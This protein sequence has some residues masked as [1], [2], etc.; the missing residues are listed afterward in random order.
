VANAGLDFALAIWI[1]NATGHG[2]GA[3]VREHIAVVRHDRLGDSQDVA[4]R[5]NRGLTMLNDNA[6]LFKIQMTSPRFLL[7]PV[8]IMHIIGAQ[9]PSSEPIYRCSRRGLG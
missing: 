1:L 5:R 8:E 2:D 3:V 6:L 9:R 7:V 4:Y